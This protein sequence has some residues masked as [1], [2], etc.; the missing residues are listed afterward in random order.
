M[1]S[2]RLKPANLAI[3]RNFGKTLEKFKREKFYKFADKIATDSLTPGGLFMPCLVNRKVFLN[4][5][6]FPEGNIRLS[7]LQKYIEIGRS[8][9]AT[10][11]EQLI[12][13]D[14]AFIKALESNKI[15]HLTVGGAVA[16]HFQEGE[17]SESK[18]DLNSKIKSG[19]KLSLSPNSQDDRFAYSYLMQ[20]TLIKNISQLDS[21]TLNPRVEIAI[22]KN[23]FSVRNPIRKMI[24]DIPSSNNKCMNLSNV[25]GNK[26]DSILT[27]NCDF[28]LG[29]ATLNDVH[30][31][32]SSIFQI[33]PEIDKLNVEDI[34]RS[35]LKELELS[36]KLHK[37]LSFFSLLKSRIPN[38]F[39]TLIK[40]LLHKNND[41]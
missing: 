21:D 23:I 37:K 24:I 25:L 12:P 15:N 1:E 8:E 13:G 28:D 6:G 5:G 2:G 26:V 4:K 40:I 11:G 34:D 30:V 17:K 10:H 33:P 20:S 31:Y 22:N 7:S 39:K 41:R 27:Q 9:I 18:E 36:F 14:L 3:K 35:V 32:F 29:L 19:I 38:R 16:Y